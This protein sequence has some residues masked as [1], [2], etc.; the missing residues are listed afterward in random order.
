M[1]SIEN[2]LVGNTLDT[3]V[4]NELDSSI[5]LTGPNKN[6]IAFGVMNNNLSASKMARTFHISRQAIQKWVTNI[7][8]G[9]TNFSGGGRPP[10]LDSTSVTRIKHIIVH[11]KQSE[12]DILKG[13]CV[14]EHRNT[15]KRRRILIKEDEIKPLSKRSKR[16]Y[17]Y[18]L[19]SLCDSS[20]DIR[21]ED[22]N[23]RA[24]DY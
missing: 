2:L 20:P 4:I 6:Y 5:E 15:M 11:E 21:D 9:R 23:E 1:S 14:D 3:L 7:R 18:Q 24:H 8:R 19:V 13:L 10:A 22:E 17:V 16:R 12:I